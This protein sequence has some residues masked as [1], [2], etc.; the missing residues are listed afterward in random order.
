MKGQMVQ[1]SS[2]FFWMSG[3]K[4]SNVQNKQQAI[5]SLLKNHLLWLHWTYDYDIR[6]MNSEQT[7][8]Y[9]GTKGMQLITALRNTE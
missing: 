8:A 4:Q 1:F 7:S 9:D 6:T 3:H 5:S 2:V